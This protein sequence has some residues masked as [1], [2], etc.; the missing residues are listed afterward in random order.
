MNINMKNHLGERIME[1]LQQYKIIPEG[2]NDYF[3]FD[4]KEFHYE[5]P[6]ENGKQ[7]LAYI[8]GW[9]DCMERENNE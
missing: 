8:I 5:G 1:S 2:I 7:I 3:Y 4:G 6:S 9:R